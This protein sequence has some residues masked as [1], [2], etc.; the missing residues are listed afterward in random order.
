MQQLAN[1]FVGRL[2]PVANHIGQWFCPLLQGLRFG[3]R[4]P[5]HL[6]QNVLAPF[7]ITKKLFRNVKFVFIN[8]NILNC[9]RFF[10]FKVK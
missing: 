6:A 7:R 8:I 5:H 2:H 4:F 1:H 9:S 3:R 10:W